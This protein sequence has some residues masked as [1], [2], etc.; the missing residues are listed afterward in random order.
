MKCIF[1]TPEVKEG[2][3]RYLLGKINRSWR[4]F[5]YRGIGKQNV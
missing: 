4:K 5:K 3:S 2:S 1:K